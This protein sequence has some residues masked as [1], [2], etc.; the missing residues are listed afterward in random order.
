MGAVI[1]TGVSKLSDASFKAR[2]MDIV[3]AII[4]LILIIAWVASIFTGTTF[5][6]TMELV[7]TAVVSHFLGKSVSVS[8]L[9][10][11]NNGS[12]TTN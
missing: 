1:N 9:G 12:T 11:A 2:L 8:A 6:Q 4:A 10:A 7:A 3:E 5:P